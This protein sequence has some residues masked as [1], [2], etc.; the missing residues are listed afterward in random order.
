MHCPEIIARTLSVPTVGSQSKG[1]AFGNSWQYHSRSD[2]HSKVACWGITLDLLTNC[3]LLRDHVKGGKV[4]LGINHEMRDYRN[5]R[6]KNLDLVLCRATES[7]SSGGSKSGKGRAST[8]A[9]LA[10]GYGIVLSQDEETALA[11]LPELPIGTVSSVL[12]AIE[13][14]AA[15]TAFQKARPRLKDELAS[16]YQT[17][18]GDSEYAIAAGLVL[19]NTST[20]FISPDMNKFDLSVADPVVSTNLQPKSAQLV[21][22]GVRELQRRSKVGDI[23]FDGL[24]VILLDCKNDHSPVK[25][26]SDPAILP[27]TDD[28]DYARF[29][30]R[31]AQVYT[32]RFTSV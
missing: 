10:N 15:M 7:G 23:G 28:F 2:R 11:G 29:I 30:H 18:H 21:V 24:G 31:L 9:E 17:I 22:S 14:K 19:V 5:N 6:K 4:H 20:E 3:P 1:F 12:L 27:S 25:V 13:S 8:F 16:S 32:T 26:V